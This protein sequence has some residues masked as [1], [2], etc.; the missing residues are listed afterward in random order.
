MHLAAPDRGLMGAS[1]VVGSQIPAAVGLAF[2]NQRLKT[3]RPTAVVFGDGALECGDFWE[4]LNAACVLRVPVLFVCEDNGYAVHTPRSAR[5]GFDRVEAVVREFWCAVS[6]KDLPDVEAIWEAA[7]VARAAVQKHSR[8]AFLRVRTCRYLD[9]IGIGEDFEAGYRTREV[10]EAWRAVDPL[11]LQRGRLLNQG[12]LEEFVAAEEQAIDAQLDEALRAAQA[13][14]APGPDEL[15]LGV[16]H[17]APAELAAEAER[18][19]RAYKAL[20]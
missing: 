5:H 3:G 18:E 7:V 13:A 1:A 2:A 6:S 9:H 10:V 4:S 19:W 16:F 20:E 15:G 11:K 14:P 17:E 8:P 12:L